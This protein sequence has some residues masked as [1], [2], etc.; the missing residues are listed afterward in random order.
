M[1]VVDY[2]IGYLAN[3]G[4][5]DFFVLT[6]SG[7]AAIIDAV[8][9]NPNVNYLA[10]MHEQAEGFAA[11]A[12]AKISENLGVAI[13]TS[14][15]G[16]HNLVTPIANCYYDSVPCVFITGQVNS[17]VLRIEN[18]LRQ[19]GFQ[20]TPIVDIVTPIT[21][22]A[23]LII[24]PKDIRYE[25]EKAVYIA[26]SKRPGPVLLDVPMDV[27]KAEIEP[28]KLI[29]FDLSA[30]ENLPNFNYLDKKIDLLI[31]DIFNSKR[32][33]FLIGSGVRLAKSVD[34]FLEVARKLKIPCF[35]T[36]NALDIVTSD[37]EYYGGRVG[38]YGGAGR[39]LGIQNSDLL[40]A[41]GSRI[42]GRITGGN[43]TSFARAAKKYV[44]DIDEPLLQK[45][46]QQLPFNECILSDAKVFLE[47]FNSALK[48][49]SIPDFSSWT[50][51][52]I[53]WKNKYDPGKFEPA[54]SEEINPYNFMRILSEMMKEKDILVGDCGGNI[55]LAS[56]A[57]ETKHSQRFITNN[58]NSPMGFSFAG[59]MGAWLASDRIHNTVC[60]IG[61]GGFNMNIQELQTVKNYN[62]KF[63]TFIIN[64]NCYGIIRA[65]Q[66]TNL[67]CRYEASGPKGYNPPDFLKI[68]QAYGIKTFS[69]ETNSEMQEKIKEVLDFDGPA[70]CNLDVSGWDNY[71]PRVSGWKTPIEDM[72]PYLPREEFKSQMI[73]P[74][75]EGWETTKY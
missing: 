55:V 57:F 1:R 48:N 15:P 49:I 11:E 58:G 35:P 12:Y 27:Q 23:K 21:K 38:T 40:I 6:G 45:K 16:G 10:V 71:E 53:D 54:D 73:I 31:K 64:N 72:E 62:L 36:W 37:F 44:I 69:I 39:N 70:V 65:F 56:Q 67:Q 32:P 59:A 46:L 2:V 63:K 28:T 3:L 18:S 33:V 4:V 5:K 51:K 26:K 47:R 34:L 25:L 42:S 30:Y 8:A 43:V 13:G 68:C 24:N 61:D 29:G 14:G 74:P 52:V 9:L 41:I 7:D 19:S 66:R 50:E 75:L 20:E 17:Q 60:I 22:Y